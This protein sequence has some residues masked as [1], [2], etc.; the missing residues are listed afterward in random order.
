M[1]IKEKSTEKNIDNF[2]CPSCFQEIPSELSEI[3]LCKKEDFQ[4]YL[5]ELKR[6]EYCK[7]IQNYLIFYENRKLIC[8]NCLERAGNSSSQPKVNNPNQSKPPQV[9]NPIPI[10]PSKPKQKVPCFS[11]KSNPGITESCIHNYCLP[12]LNTLSKSSISKDPF[13]PV[14]CEKCNFPIPQSEVILSF[15]SELNFTKYQEI[16]VNNLFFAVKFDCGVCMNNFRIEEGITFDC[17]HRFCL[18]CVKEYFREKIMSSN[19]SEDELVCPS[20]GVAIDHNIIQGI[21]RELYDKYVNFAFRNWR[22]QDGAI[23]KYCCFCDAAAEIA[24]NAKRFKCPKCQKAY[25]PQC[26]KD[27]L[28]RISCEDFVNMEERQKEENEKVENNRRM[29]EK[30]K[31][32]IENEKFFEEQKKAVPKAN[33]KKDKGQVNCI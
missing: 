29:E 4:G 28:E 15:T 10:I 27:H 5:K 21:D 16:C 18:N 23:L 2:Y 9:P 3:F 8:L 33:D 31:K 17:D 32:E 7:N 11:C 14:K 30:K 19:V 12:C 24:E 20:C 25:C 1:F 6:C 26:N 22:P 13:S